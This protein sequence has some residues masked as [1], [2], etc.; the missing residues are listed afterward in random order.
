MLTILRVHAD[1]LT[2]LSKQA[3]QSAKGIVD[4]KATRVFGPAM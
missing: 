3:A 2:A 1:S 4:N